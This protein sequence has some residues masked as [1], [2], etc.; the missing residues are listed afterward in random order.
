LLGMLTPAARKGGMQILGA[1]TPRGEFLGLIGLLF[2]PVSWIG[3]GVADSFG[4]VH[5]CM[6]FCRKIFVGGVAWETT[7]GSKQFFWGSAK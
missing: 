4:L 1:A 3:L 6:R 5:P 7:E 2:G